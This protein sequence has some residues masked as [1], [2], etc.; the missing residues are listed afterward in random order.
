M[1]GELASPGVGKPGREPRATGAIRGLTLGSTL[2]LAAVATAC[3]T[4]TGGESSDGAGDRRDV[5]TREELAAI[6]ETEDITA[7]EAIQRLHPQWLRGR[8]S[9]SFRLSATVK[10]HYNG[11]RIGEVEELRRFRVRDVQYI[12][13]MEGPQATQRFGTGYER[14]VILVYGRAGT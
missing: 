5:I 2:F 9:V 14:G 7:Y 12:E 4:G 13:H 1:P 10:V 8:G 11:A 6:E 3:A